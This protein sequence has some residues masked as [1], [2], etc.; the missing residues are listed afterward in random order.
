[1]GQICPIHEGG[2]QP[3]EVEPT[4]DKDLRDTP[5]TQ[6]EIAEDVARQSAH[7][8]MGLAAVQH[9]HR[10]ALSPDDVGHLAEIM[11]EIAATIAAA[12]RDDG[13]VVREGSIGDVDLLSDAG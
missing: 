12:G 6:A 4:G 3:V 10:S 8:L 9:R 2:K 7:F 13:T 11:L 1:M 5:A